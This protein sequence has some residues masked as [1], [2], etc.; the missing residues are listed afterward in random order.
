MFKKSGGEGEEGTSSS[1]SLRGGA[2]GAG[3]LRKLLRMVEVALPVWFMRA[4]CRVGGLIGSGIWS[5][6]AENTFVVAFLSLFFSVL[7]KT[8]AEFSSMEWV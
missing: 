2:L 1:S 6:A 5:D 7:E 4:V 8:L 3:L